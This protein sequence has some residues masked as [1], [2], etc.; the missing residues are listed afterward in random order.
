MH[1]T[2]IGLGL[3]IGIPLWALTYWWTKRNQKRGYGKGLGGGDY[4]PNDS[5]HGGGGDF[6]G[7]DGGGGHSA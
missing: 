3:V 7:G 2:S 1:W 4:S 6:G 5:H